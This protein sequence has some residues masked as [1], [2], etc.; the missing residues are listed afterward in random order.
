MVGPPLILT[1]F[2]APTPLL[3]G[4]EPSSSTFVFLNLS[5]VARVTA[6]MPPSNGASAQDGFTSSRCAHA[7]LP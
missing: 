2:K 6:V 4:P 1:R 7:D 3:V 5:V